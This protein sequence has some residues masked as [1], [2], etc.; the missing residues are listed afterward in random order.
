M[1]LLITIAISGQLSAIS[2]Q[3]SVSV[4]VSIVSVRVSVNSQR[5]AFLIIP[6]VFF[7]REFKVLKCS[8]FHVNL[9]VPAFICSEWNPIESHLPAMQVT[10]N[11]QR[12]VRQLLQLKVPSR[13]N[14]DFPFRRKIDI[15][16]HAKR[17]NDFSFILHQITYIRWIIRQR[18]VIT[19]RQRP[20]R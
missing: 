17:L 7:L 19:Q 3:Q 4:S 11:R 1:Q 16:I 15:A 18:K 14:R 13:L 8:G 2:Y 6:I 9:E 10:I 5:S 20:L 12:G